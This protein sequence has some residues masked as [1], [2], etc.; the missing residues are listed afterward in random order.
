MGNQTTKLI[1]EKKLVINQLKN[2]A[3]SGKGK[4]RGKR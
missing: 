3:K 2:D 4:C 1:D